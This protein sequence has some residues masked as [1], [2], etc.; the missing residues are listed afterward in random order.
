[1]APAGGSTTFRGSI[2]DSGA[3]NAV[4]L[5]KNGVGT[6]ILAG[7]NTYVGTTTVNAGTLGVGSAGALQ[8]L[9]SKVCYL[10]HQ[11]R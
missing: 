10:A 2:Q 1:M 4:T 5:I 11:G 3:A 7:A 6:Q 8:T 9:V